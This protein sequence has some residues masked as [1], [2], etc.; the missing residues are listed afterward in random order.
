MLTGKINKP[1]NNDHTHDKIES[2]D[3][4]K[5]I[6]NKDEAIEHDE[7]TNLKT[8]TETKQSVDI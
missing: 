5:D 2:D 7:T 4:E 8:R 6:E 3:D 1:E